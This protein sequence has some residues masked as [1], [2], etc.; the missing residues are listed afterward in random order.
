VDGD[1]RHDVA[2]EQRRDEILERI[3]WLSRPGGAAPPNLAALSTELDALVTDLE[4]LDPALADVLRQEWWRLESLHVGWTR[5]I[6]I[7][8]RRLVETR[9]RRLHTIARVG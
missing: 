9:L 4:T 6:P 2:A 1:R 8:S 3:R 7:L 5:R